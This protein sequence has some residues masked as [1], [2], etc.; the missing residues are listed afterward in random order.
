MKCN[1]DNTVALREERAISL[2]T[3]TPPSNILDTLW[4]IV[5]HYSTCHRLYDEIY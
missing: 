5:L 1:I 3:T 2:T 4:K